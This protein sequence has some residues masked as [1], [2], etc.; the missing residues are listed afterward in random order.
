MILFKFYV[1]QFAINQKHANNIDIILIFQ[2]NES[3][4]EFI[5]VREKTI[6]VFIP[7]PVVANQQYNVGF[8]N[9]NEFVQF[10]IY[11]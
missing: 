1:N 10:N 8:F 7:S 5:F 6:N 4:I 11:L 2:G 3:T 9:V